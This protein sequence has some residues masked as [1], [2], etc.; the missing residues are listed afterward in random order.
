M[1]MMAATT[2]AMTVA[3][4]TS[5]DVHKFNLRYFKIVWLVLRFLLKKSL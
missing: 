1:T 3:T 5:F 4:D 2:A